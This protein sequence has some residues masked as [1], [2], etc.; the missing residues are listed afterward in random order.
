VATIEWLRLWPK[1]G[2]LPQTSHTLGMAGEYRADS[3]ATEATYPA[4]S[5]S[6]IARAASAAAAA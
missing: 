6:L 1:A 5:R 2:R 4:A 3:N